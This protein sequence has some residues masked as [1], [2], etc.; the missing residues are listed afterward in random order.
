MSQV[1]TQNNV[2]EI[3]Q[4]TVIAEQSM[5]SFGN[6]VK[7]ISKIV[8]GI[9]L[10]Q[11]KDG[12]KKMRIIGKMIKSYS[13][14]LSDIINT[15][16]SSADSSQ[17]AKIL[18]EETKPETQSDGS[19]KQVTKWTNLDALLQV[20][21]IMSS[22]IKGMTVV[23][24]LEKGGLFAR[25]KMKQNIK[26]SVNLAMYAFK[27]MT[28]E[29]S[30]ISEKG[31]FKDL[32]DVLVDSPELIKE[33]IT[34]K[35]SSEKLKDHEKMNIYDTTDRITKKGK[36]G[37]LN[38]LKTMFDLLTTMIQ[39]EPPKGLEMI[40]FR[41]KIKTFGVMMSYTVEQMTTMLRSLGTDEL[42]RLSVMS[43]KVISGTGKEGEDGVMG[44]IMNMA[45]MMEMI[46]DMPNSKK[47]D[48]KILALYKTFS[49]LL[50]N[51][52]N[53][54][55]DKKTLKPKKYIETLISKDFNKILERVEESIQKITDVI[56]HVTSLASK[57][58]ALG[59]IAIIAIVVSPLVAALFK[60]INWL[61]KIIMKF[62]IDTNK[63]S[64]W[65]D[66][67]ESLN[68]LLIGLLKTQFLIISVAIVSLTAIPAMGINIIFLVCLLG[69]VKLM[70]L[71]LGIIYKSIN[72]RAR[73]GTRILLSLLY[74]ILLI[75]FALIAIALTAVPTIAAILIDIVLLGAIAL[76]V[77][78]SRGLFEVISKLLT[79]KTM[80]AMMELIGFLLVLL[81]ITSIMLVF[82]VLV[83]PATKACWLGILFVIGLIALTVLLTV[84]GALA[85]SFA[86]IIGVAI[87]GLLAIGALL[88]T[89]I[90]I[91]IILV[92]MSILF[93]MLSFVSL[94]AGLM[95]MIV[96]IPLAI[97]IGIIGL[98]SIFAIPGALLTTVLFS[99]ILIIAVSLIIIQSLGLNMS[100]LIKK[101]EIVKSG[102]NAATDAF[103]KIQAFELLKAM[104][105][106]NTAIPLVTGLVSLGRKL[107]KL[108]RFRLD[109][110]KVISN[111]QTIFETVREIEKQIKMFSGIINEDGKVDIKALAKNT[112]D[113]IVKGIT[114]KKKMDRSDAVL[115][116]VYSIAK[117][118]NKIQNIKL[119]WDKIKNSLD[120]CFDTVEAITAYVNGRD[121]VPKDD[122][123]VVKEEINNANLSV[124]DRLKFKTKKKQLR[125][126]DIILSKVYNIA[127]TLQD[128]EKVK[129]D[130]K[131]I[132]SKVSELLGVVDLIDAVIS[133]KLNISDAEKITT[134]EKRA[135]RRALRF[136]NK[137][138]KL[139]AQNVDKMT[140]I[141]S[142]VSEMIDIMKD[143]KTL[144]FDK[145]TVVKNAGIIFDAAEEIHQ[146][147]VKRF[148]DPV[149]DT[150]F[151]TV[152]SHVRL[153]N[154]EITGLSKLT[155]KDV[156]NTKNTLE[157]YTDFLTK[158]D[159]LKVENLKQSAHLFEQMANFSKTIEGN[160]EKLADTVN[161]KLMP[162]LEELKDIMDGASDKLEKG[163]NST[164]ET[165]VATSPVPVSKSGMKGIVKAR[166]PEMSD[167][168]ASAAADKKLAA[169]MRSQ[170]QTLASKL[171]ELID[172]LSGRGRIN[173]MVTY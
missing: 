150:N 41:K 161:E 136:E 147:I 148:S 99:L 162:V 34:H 47:I 157:Y 140:V 173:A 149:D 12:D 169:Q 82:A 29:I 54:F 101:I 67:L 35:D 1:V 102:V 117:K 45:N 8:D 19:I 126:S 116:K 10:D 153:A 159:G 69:F 103:S 120:V 154:K 106:V 9:E 78:I 18:G 51:I 83:K 84:L 172:L 127:K 81:V 107:R 20:S 131:T 59:P 55:V 156:T 97:L 31:A 27:H 114:T 170:N 32:L 53:L 164:N 152:M 91:A 17:L 121:S 160:F 168:Q 171:D 56:N 135:M 3:V 16:T 52:I 133:D 7:N 65:L 5:K 134:V 146:L 139:Q 125:K 26:D 167:S 66:S 68:D 43:C 24:G 22:L 40:K 33:T 39:L 138:K 25:M 145:D 37:L 71:I 4:S 44:V 85:F 60:T 98:G 50:T 142:N 64:K 49:N 129:I 113:N 21:T 90:P 76:F 15:L 111:V 46:N 165:L 94:I 79:I 144:E 87:L 72:T 122:Q 75:Q 110:E 58:I 2:S 36:V 62:E 73:R 63:I 96:V 88:M 14:S 112:L 119:E 151:N 74:N 70:N 118:L 57:I 77:V 93:K 143:L 89:L 115:I 38:A 48:K 100:E 92:S 13:I 80:L 123:D 124:F 61:L 105:I 95:T 28:R 6:M 86:P 104:F 163:F 166:N 155:D 23:S 141:I 109:R 137:M 128:I 130:E 30:A 108:Q 132:V 158:V 11:I 42:L